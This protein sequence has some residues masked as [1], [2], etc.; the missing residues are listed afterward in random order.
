MTVSVS[1]VSD[2]RPRLRIRFSLWRIVTCLATIPAERHSS[3]ARGIGRTIDI[4]FL[5]FTHS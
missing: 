5:Y 4:E 1:R 2:L 3:Q